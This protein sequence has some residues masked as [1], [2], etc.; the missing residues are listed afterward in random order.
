MHIFPFSPTGTW[1]IN[2]STT[3]IN[4]R[5]LFKFKTTTC[6]NETTGSRSTV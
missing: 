3:P 4:T 6:G 5:F 1:L 2:F